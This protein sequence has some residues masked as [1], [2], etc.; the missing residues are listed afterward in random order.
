MTGC[1][2]IL[3]CSCVKGEQSAVSE[4]VRKLEGQFLKMSNAELSRNDLHACA[5]NLLSWLHVSWFDLAI[6][7]SDRIFSLFCF[8]TIHLKSKVLLLCQ[9]GF[10]SSTASKNCWYCQKELLKT[11]KIAK[12]DSLSGK[13]S[14]DIASSSLR[15]W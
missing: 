5:A 7:T 6:Q 9:G 14:E 11:S 3:T 10:K 15:V 4:L 13:E 1:L 12:S 2:T 8:Y